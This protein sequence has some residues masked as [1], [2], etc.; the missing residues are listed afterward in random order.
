MPEYE[1]LTTETDMTGAYIIAF[2]VAC[3]NDCG[4]GRTVFLTANVS[5]PAI[6]DALVNSVP[7]NVRVVEAPIAVR[8]GLEPT[9]VAIVYNVEEAVIEDDVVAVV[10]IGRSEVTEVST[11][12]GADYQLSLE[13]G[14][15][16]VMR[17][18]EDTGITVTT[19]VS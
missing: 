1:V 3:G 18:S 2:Q 11:Y 13:F 4:S 16:W 17:T 6:E 5:D 10:R 12:R 19:S 9:E 7:A 15:G 14:G 8:P